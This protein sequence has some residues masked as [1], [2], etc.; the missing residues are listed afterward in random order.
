MQNSLVMQFQGLEGPVMH[1]LRW[2]LHI[3]ASLL[4]V[5]TQEFLEMFPGRRASS[6]WCPEGEWCALRAKEKEEWK[7]WKNGGCP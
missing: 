7:R 3:S 4:L 2:S 1:P 5:T 6:P